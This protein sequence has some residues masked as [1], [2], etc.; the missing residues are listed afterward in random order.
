MQLGVLD[1]TLFQ[2]STVYSPS[3]WAFHTDEGVTG[4]SERRDVMQTPNVEVHFM[5]LMFK[6]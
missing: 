3:F 2:M 5:F 1:G 6:A 4:T